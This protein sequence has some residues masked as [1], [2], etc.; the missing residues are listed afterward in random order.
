[1]FGNTIE[2][3]CQSIKIMKEK[4]SKIKNSGFVQ[5]WKDIL[6]SKFFPFITAAISL[7]CYYLGLDIVFIYYIGITGLIILLF[8]DDISP[9]ITLLLFMCILISQENSPSNL[10]E[11]S[12]YYFNPA[13]LTQIFVLIGIL[14]L[15]L[16]YRVTLT[17]I[18]K[19]FSFSP[20]FWGLCAFSVVLLLNGLFSTDY[21]TKNLVYGLV[22]MLCFL[23]I[24][25]ALKDNLIMTDEAFERIALSLFA[26]SIVL[27]FELLAAYFTVD[28]LY[29]DG[30]FYREKL[31]F[32]WGMWNTM[33]MMLLICLPA[34]FYLASKYKHG[35]IF[36][37]FATVL[38]VAI[39]M[40]CSRQAM[41]ASLLLYPIC[42]I[43]LLVKGT[44]CLANICIVICSL[45]AVAI[46]L[47]SKDT[48]L[49]YFKDLISKIVVNGELYGSGRVRLWEGGIEYFKSAPFL[50]VGFYSNLYKDFQDGFTGFSGMSFIPNMCHNTLIQLL[51]AC[52][53][54]GLLTYLIHRVQTIISFFKN[55]TFDRTFIALT[56]LALLIVCLVDNH[57]FNIFPTIIYSILIAVLVASEKKTNKS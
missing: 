36:T 34:V 54:I 28:G 47:V 2:F 56:I 15:A 22:M 51:S 29:V 32:G 35:F 46:L 16:I 11:S 7:F 40:S 17:C 25:V 53:I 52:G 18:K 21:N 38:F 30:N 44:N 37:M 12:A 31:T 48:I 1:M 57:I 41:L 24:F 43:I 55:I 49:N 3:D 50:G 23:G 4:F 42:L 27:I 26:L 14:S 20:I 45:V 8:L 33:G 5:A 10:S 6:F 19:Q 9:L 13:I 39:W